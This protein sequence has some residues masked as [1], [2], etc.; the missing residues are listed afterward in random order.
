[1]GGGDGGADFLGIVRV[2]IDDANAAFGLADDFEPAGDAGKRR[3]RRRDV[4]GG[5]AKFE[6]RLAEDSVIASEQPALT[7]K[8]PLCVAK[9]SNWRCNWLTS[10]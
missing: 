7:N 1:M 5:D 8:A 10:A 3:Q 9:A 6:R 2:I 4:R